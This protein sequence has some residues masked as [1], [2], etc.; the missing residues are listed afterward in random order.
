SSEHNESLRAIEQSRSS[1]HSESLQAMSS[2]DRNAYGSSEL[3]GEPLTLPRYRLLVRRAP[4]EPY[5]TRR[6]GEGKK[7]KRR[8]QRR[9][10]PTR[11]ARRESLAKTQQRV[12]C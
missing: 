3:A 7:R 4:R 10:A 9:P 1:E 8:K 11:K 12:S 5:A 2:P 6:R